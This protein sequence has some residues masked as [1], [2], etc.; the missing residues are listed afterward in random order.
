M[1]PDNSNLS[2][3]KEENSFPENKEILN[4]ETK[5]GQKVKLMLELYPTTQ[6]L[7]ILC[8][9]KKTEIY[10]LPANFQNKLDFLLKSLQPSIKRKTNL[11]EFSLELKGRIKSIDSTFLKD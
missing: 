5:D 3:Y 11:E 10:I 6:I 2:L 1:E 4:Y 8:N 7:S 9:E